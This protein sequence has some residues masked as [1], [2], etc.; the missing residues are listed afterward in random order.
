MINSILNE[1]RTPVFLVNKNN[2]V[3][4][5][6]SIGEEF[7][8]HSANLIIGFSIYNL[9][10][11][12]S[13]VSI[14]LKRVRKSKQGLTEESLDFS[15]INFPNRKVRAHIVPLSFDSNQIIFQLSEL[16]V[17][18]MFQSQRI[19]SKISKSFSSMVD[20]LMH[21]LKN[22]LA[23][24]KGASQLIES[25]LNSDKNVKELTSLINIESDRIVS[26]LNRMEQINNN[27]VIKDQEFLNVHEILNHCKRVAQNSFGSNIKYIESFDPSLPHIF[28]NKDILIQ[29]FLNL[30]KNACE[31]AS[32]TSKIKIKTSFNSDKKISFSHEEIP[33]S[34]P[35]QIE[36]IDYGTGITKSLLPNIF[37]PF[38]SSKKEGKGLGLSIVASGLNDMGAVIDVMSSPGLTNFIINFPLKKNK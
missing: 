19:N 21:E 30:L 23:G 35:L 6:N 1:L 12:D 13:P 10:P 7:F 18:E 2:D 4:Y 3:V 31:A 9:I 38:I 26:L 25:D 16:T 20:M 8:G 14:L 36:I 37:D 24:I 33:S 34:L 28:A 5:I 15:N 29:I 11:E 17:S 22:P 32:N 27:D